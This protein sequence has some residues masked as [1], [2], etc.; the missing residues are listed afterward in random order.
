MSSQ[1]GLKLS[2]RRGWFSGD[3]TQVKTDFFK[4]SADVIFKR[5]LRRY[6]PLSYKSLARNIHFCVR[7]IT[8]LMH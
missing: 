8:C 7:L 3:K 1:A 5:G 6:L 2:R 4:H